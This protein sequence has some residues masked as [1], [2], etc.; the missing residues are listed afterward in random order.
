MVSTDGW[1]NTQVGT[2][3]APRADAVTWTAPVPPG[4]QVV[5][6]TSQCPAQATPLGA[7]FKTDVSLDEKVKVVLRLTPEAVCADAL[8]PNVAP[9]SEERSVGHKWRS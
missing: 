2:L 5:K 9:R 8:K 1:T 7:R 6:A 3:E 4:V